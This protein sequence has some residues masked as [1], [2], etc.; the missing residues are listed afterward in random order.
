[1]SHEM[2]TNVIAKRERSSWI[3]FENTL[4]LNQI[5]P[6]QN[7]YYLLMCITKIIQNR[8]GGAEQKIPNYKC[9]IGFRGLPTQTPV[10]P[11]TV[12]A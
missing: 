9:Y 3:I 7:N 2:D 11:S 1:M 5:T 6:R 10:K 4:E 8:A 12:E